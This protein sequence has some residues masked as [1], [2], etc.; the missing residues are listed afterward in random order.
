MRCNSHLGY[1][2]EAMNEEEEFEYDYPEDYSSYSQDDI[3]DMLG[4]DEDRIDSVL[5][6]IFKS[7]PVPVRSVGY[8]SYRYNH[9]KTI[10]QFH[11]KQAGNQH[12]LE[13]SWSLGSFS[14]HH[15]LYGLDLDSNPPI[16]YYSYKYV[17]GQKCD[18]I[19]APRETE[20][21]FEPCDERHV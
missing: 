11:K 16:P 14:D 15:G 4:V 8:W 21:R 17:N 9:K 7:I 12:D 13:L 18:E 20:V 19:S 6:E 10:E 2:V 5:D 1:F 3:A